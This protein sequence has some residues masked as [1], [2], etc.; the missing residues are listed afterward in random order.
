[1][2][3]E[4]LDMK[5]RVLI[6]DDEEYCRQQLSR[7]LGAEQQVEIVAECANGIEALNA[8]E[9]TRPDLAFLDI[10]MP[11][12][13]GFGIVE[14]L[15]GGRMPAIIFVSAFDHFA[16][17]AFDTEAVDYLL[18]PFDQ[19]RFRRAFGRAVHSVTDG[20]ARR[21]ATAIQEILQAAKSGGK[22]DRR[23]TIKTDG[24]F[25]LIDPAEVD[26]I[27]SA[28]NYSELHIGR[29][30]HLWR[31]TISA[32]GERLAGQGF[33][34]ISRS[35]LVNEHRISQIQL[36]SH[37]DALITLASGEAVT[38]TRTFRPQWR[39]LMDRRL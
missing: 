26:W 3:R 5:L 28:D 38:A 17:R 21:N 4:D 36:K 13:D 31:S 29:K 9:Q 10:H 37:G 19:E 2:S 34:Q 22:N 15:D 6:A 23:F 25:V 14:A 20:A 11:E 1:M 16:V 12:L 7:L 24:R 32:L 33:V 18:K 8:V 35:A 27:S 30:T 39:G